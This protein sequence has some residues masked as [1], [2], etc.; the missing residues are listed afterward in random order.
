MLA[1]FYEFEGLLMAL[2]LKG[3][4]DSGDYAV[5]GVDP[6][7]YDASDPEKYIEG[8]KFKLTL[9]SHRRPELSINVYHNVI[10]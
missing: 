3:V 10:Q 7:Q 1:E 6:K 4:M 2:K 8:T 9:K 5:I